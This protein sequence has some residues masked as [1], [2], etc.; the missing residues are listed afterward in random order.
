MGFP[1]PFFASILSKSR[2]L[3]SRSRL[4]RL[5]RS[6]SLADCGR[7]RAPEAE[8]ARGPLTKHFKHFLGLRVSEPWD[9]AR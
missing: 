2:L 6:R 7:Q 8:I 9:G 1:V 3:A 4:D 5:L